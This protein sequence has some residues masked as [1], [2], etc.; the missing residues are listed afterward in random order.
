MS[1]RRIRTWLVAGLLFPA[2][3]VL[4]PAQAQFGRPPIPPGGIAG[5]GGIGG[6]PG[7]INGGIGGMPG[8]I[9]G[10]I[11][12]GIGGMPA[13]PQ[14]TEWVCGGCGKVLGVGPVKP[15]MPSC[16]FCGVKFT[17]GMDFEM[18]R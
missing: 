1:H 3:L 17:N 12:G 13:G 4:T 2:A 9:R 8:G 15:I 16:P 14:Q 18:N 5:R 11:G 6:M 7:G 10:G